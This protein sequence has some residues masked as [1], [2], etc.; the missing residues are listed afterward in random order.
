MRTPNRRRRLD[1]D[2]TSL[3]QLYQI[4]ESQSEEDDLTEDMQDQLFNFNLSN[5]ATGTGVRT[6]LRSQVRDFID[7]DD[8]EESNTIENPERLRVTRFINSNIREQMQNLNLTQRME[9]QINNLNST[10]LG[11]RQLLNVSQNDDS[12]FVQIIRLNRE[13]ITKQMLDETIEEWKDDLLRLRE[14]QYTQKQFFHQLY[15]DYGS[16]GLLLASRFKKNSDYEGPFHQCPNKFCFNIQK[17]KPNNRH[18]GYFAQLR[19]FRKDPKFQ[20]NVK[21][22]KTLLKSAKLKQIEGGAENKLVE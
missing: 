16:L 17:G 6:A 8:I 19:L 11:V 18:T 22:I 2:Q 14:D 5:G 13:R 3:E 21:A 7:I 20:I 10:M 15:Q 12:Q 9:E 1:T 4:R